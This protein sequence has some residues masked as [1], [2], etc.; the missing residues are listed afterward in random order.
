MGDVGLCDLLE[1]ALEGDEA[2]RAAIKDA[3]LPVIEAM[4]TGE[5]QA[6]DTAAAAMAADL[7]SLLDRHVPNL[8][9]LYERLEAVVP[10]DTAAHVVVLREH[11]ARM[12]AELVAAGPS[13]DA[14]GA[15]LDAPDGGAAEAVR[16]LTKL[17]KERC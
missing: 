1:P 5:Q 7:P 10:A 4:Q 11:T 3:L 12:A 13:F 16:A 2:L 14:I 9:E 15:V 6:V 8:L 17:R